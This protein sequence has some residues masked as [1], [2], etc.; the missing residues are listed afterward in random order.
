MV[1]FLVTDAFK[2]CGHLCQFGRL[3]IGVVRLKHT[4]YILEAFS[5]QWC[6]QG[7]S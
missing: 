3:L 7:L 1:L 5:I 2:A 6:Q 4:T